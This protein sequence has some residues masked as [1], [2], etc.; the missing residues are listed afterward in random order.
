VENII[1]TTKTGKLKGLKNAKTNQFLGIPYALAPIGKNRFKRAIPL[2]QTVETFDCTKFGNKAPQPKAGTLQIENDL[3]QSEDCLYL[4]IWAPK[5]N[6]VNK[7]VLVWIHGGAY[8]LGETSPK[9]FDGENFSVNGDIIFVSI[10]YRLGVFGFMDF[11]YLN[12]DSHLFDTNIGLSDQIQALK[13]INENITNFGGD[14]NNITLMGESAGATSIL[15]LM[16]SPK[17]ENLFQKAI[18]QSPVVDILLSKKNARFW[19]EKAMDLMGLKSNDKSGLFNVPQEKVIDA[20]LEISQTFTEIMPGSWPF[21]PIIDDL[22]PNTII[23]AYKK[24]EI[25]NIPLLIGINKDESSNFVKEIYPWLPSNEVHIDRMF[26]FNP[27]LDK[28]KILSNYPSYPSISALREIGRDMSFVGGCIKVSDMN[29]KKRNT[30]VYRF[31]YETTICKQLSIGA[32]HGIEIMFAFNNLNCELS[33]ILT[34]ETTNPAI[35]SNLV[36]NYWINFVKNSN[37]NSKE[38]FTWEKYTQKN[39]ETILLDVEPA[40]LLNP[41]KTGY[42]IWENYSLY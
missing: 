9:I 27:N 41:D 36:H 22:L 31:N 16:A 14:K 8:L 19:A 11:S 15:S 17:A 26:E 29:S 37:P 38:L 23:D 40:V 32:F 35:V 30:Y 33:K 1:V 42:E 5:E 2:E 7:P 3:L 6:K 12:Y 21:G 13:W 18:C 20:T 24:N 10:Q 39:R 34:Y 28:Q 4:N 25:M